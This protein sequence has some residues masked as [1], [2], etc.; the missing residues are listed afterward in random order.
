MS[1][2]PEVIT[3]S[4]YDEAKDAYR[5]KDLRQALYDAGEVIMGDVLVNLHGS[6]HRD[7]RRLENRL[8]RRETY[9]TYERTLFPPIIES[10]LAPHVA[11]GRAELVDLGHQLMMN[12]AAS[13]AGVDRPLGTPDETHRLYD[14]LM[15][16]IEGATL[17][18]FTG[19]KE[20]KRNE[21]AAKLSEFDAEFVMPSLARRR[22]IQSEG[23]ELPKDVMSILLA[24]EDQLHLP[25]DILVREVAF[26]LLA[27][28]HTSATA[29]TR[30][31]HNIFRWLADHP[32]DATLISSDRS[33]V[34]RCTHE[35]V[36]LQPSSPVAMRWALSD[37]QLKSGRSIPR[38][39]KVIIDL[40]A[41]NRD[42]SV[43]GGDAEEFNPHRR[44]PDG[45]SQYG[46]SFGSGMHACIGQDLAAG[47]TAVDEVDAE[48]TYG[49]VPCAVQALFDHGARPDPNDP[50][51][52]DE[53]TTRPY[54]GRYPVVFGDR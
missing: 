21:V 47:L 2:E 23:G 4:T 35:T 3:I 40:L 19:D 51:V 28:A 53:S 45:V 6:E 37:V 50:P 43:F 25:H 29:F 18:H 8:F 7:R 11:T 15:R 9:E 5:Q 10:T 48:H 49:L 41:V 42:A 30:V 17:A 13:T 22:A 32:E 46:L 20:A 36:R 12:L 44:T 38:G 14:Y 52:M 33:F 39:S 24:N 34:Q 26:Y 16:F 54:F 27:G 1:A 31:T